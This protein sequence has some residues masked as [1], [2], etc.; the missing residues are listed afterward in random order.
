MMRVTVRVMGNLIGIIG[1]NSF[2][3]KLDKNATIHDLLKKISELHGE[4][5]KKEVLN[6]EGKGLAPRYKILINGKNIKTMDYF[7]TVLE[8]GQTIHIMPP[9]AGG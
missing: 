5:F 4:K 3:I 9:V 7:D 2:V 1:C 8:N 6:Q